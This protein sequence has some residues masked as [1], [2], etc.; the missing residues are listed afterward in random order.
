[1]YNCGTYIGMEPSATY[2]SPKC[3]KR[4]ESRLNA[5]VK[6]LEEQVANMERTL[7]YD[8]NLLTQTQENLRESWAEAGK[9]REF[10]NDVEN[11]RRPMTQN[12]IILRRQTRGLALEEPNAE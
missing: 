2:R 11:S 4:S 9:W 7:G 6:E 5:R 3:F 12:E 8:W 1:M 10:V